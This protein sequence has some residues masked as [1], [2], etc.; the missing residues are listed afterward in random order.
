MEKQQHLLF[1]F[2]LK[3]CNAHTTRNRDIERT[4]HSPTHTP[5]G[6]CCENTTYC[7]AHRISD[8]DRNGDERERENMVKGLE[9]NGME[10]GHGR[11]FIMQGYRWNGGCY[12]F[13]LLLF[14]QV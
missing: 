7:G 2:N 1:Q 4:Q 8:S 5:N 14:E 9:Q 6:N 3:P 10:K 12:C 11:R 13:L